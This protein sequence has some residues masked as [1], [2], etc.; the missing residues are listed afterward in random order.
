MTASRRTAEPNQLLGDFVLRCARPAG[1]KAATRRPYAGDFEVTHRH[2][3]YDFHPYHTKVPP[4]VIRTLIEHYTDPGDLVLDAFAGTGMTG[5]AARE[6]GRNAIVS[7]LCPIASFIA[8]V[9]TCNHDWGSFT[10]TFTGLLEKSREQLGWVYATGQEGGPQANYFVW[11]DVFDCPYCGKRFPFFP[12]GVIHHGNKV[13]TRKSFGCPG[14]AADLNV[15]RV[16][17]VIEDGRKLSELVWVNAGKGK[18]RVSSRPGPY[19]LELAVRVESTVPRAWFP[20]DPINPGGYSA[21]LAQLG[22]KRITDVSRMLSRR[23]LLVFSD[24]WERVG[25]L[26]DTRLGN[27]GKAVL[28]SVFTVI[29]ERQGY[30]G[31]GGGMSGN[32]YMPIVRMEKNV[33]D[34]LERKLR[35]TRAAEK[36]KRGLKGEVAVSTQSATDLHQIPDN[37]ID[38]IYTDPPFGSN[39]IYSEMN[40]VLEAWLGVRTQGDQEAVIDPSRAKDLHSYAELMVGAFKEY[41]RVLKPGRWMTVEFHNSK[42][43]IWNLFQKVLMDCGFVV[44]HAGV[45]D[46]GSTTILSDIRPGAAKFDLVISAYKPLRAARVS[47]ALSQGSVEETWAFMDEHL[48]RLPLPDTA[49]PMVKERTKHRLFDAMLAYHVARGLAVPM[50]TAE[51]YAGLERRYDIRDRMY[52]PNGPLGSDAKV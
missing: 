10:R 36:A 2:P 22:D 40:T 1:R 26:D 5:V 19:D 47:T 31:G 34:V 39:I 37:S 15:R 51:F 13:E 18:R 25:R 41:H 27:L 48:A 4:V 21:K 38:Y 24:L 52:L 23:N 30:F 3:V 42:A 16:E 49:T 32:F 33:Y 14:C 43:D 17:R 11:S 20:T 35:R 12:H 46:K 44:A 9:N 6:A 8:S 7:D 29:S 45:I 50:S 28:T